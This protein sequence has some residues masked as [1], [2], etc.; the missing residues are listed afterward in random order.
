MTELYW[1]HED[2]G[3]TPALVLLAVCTAVVMIL[4]AACVCIQRTVDTL[5]RPSDD[6]LTHLTEPIEVRAHTFP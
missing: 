6:L 5:A 2:P 1:G 3:A 4:M